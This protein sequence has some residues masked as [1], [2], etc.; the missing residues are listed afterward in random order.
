MAHRTASRIPFAFVIVLTSCGAQPPPDA[1]LS[2]VHEA[3][4]AANAPARLEWKVERSFSKLPLTAKT[5][6]TPWADSYWPTYR[7]GLAWRW[8]ATGDT[9][10]FGYNLYT[11]EQAKSLSPSQ[12]TSL[13][14]AE[15]YDI[16]QGR[17][18]YPLVTAEWRRTKPD[19]EAWE[20]LCHGWAFAAVNFPEPKPLVA[21]SVD[22]IEIPFGSSDIK[23]LLTFYQGETFT[24]APARRFLGLRCNV[25]LAENPSAA[26]SRACRD[27]NAGS[28][29]L[30]LANSL[31]RL[32]RPLIA[33][34]TRDYEVWNH[35]LFAFRT[36]VLG[37]QPPSEGASPRAVREVRVST[38]IEYVREGNP[39][40]ETSIGTPFNYTGSD[41]FLY[42]LELDADDAVVGGEWESDARPDF[43]WV[44]ERPKFTN[45]YAK[46]GELLEA[47]TRSEGSRPE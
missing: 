37:S 34:I 38:R 1:P 25:D 11:R 8:Q 42:R 9:T 20:G 27:T 18:D 16:L 14:P 40:W 45:Y 2:R 30:L 36:Q 21:R 33:D 19:A 47:S 35:P 31:G 4:D 24:P 17:F 26:T 10:S 7:G 23:A 5:S 3:W 32:D 43:L 46:L 29:H 44:H 39:R 15:K 41:V 22:G 12:L 28:F 6:V 13:S